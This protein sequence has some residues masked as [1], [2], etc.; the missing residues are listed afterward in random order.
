MVTLFGKILKS[1]HVFSS[2]KEKAKDASK[3][4]ETIFG[5][6]MVFILQKNI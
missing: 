3:Y 4:P 1:H 5:V 6:Y 2:Q